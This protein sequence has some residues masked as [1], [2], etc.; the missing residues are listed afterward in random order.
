MVN[1]TSQ[2]QIYMTLTTLRQFSVIACQ[3]VRQCDDVFTTLLSKAVA[4]LC[5]NFFKRLVNRNFVVFGTFVQ[6]QPSF[7][8]KTN[9]ANESFFVFDFM[10]SRQICNWSADSLAPLFFLDFEVSHKPRVTL[11][12]LS[13][14][15]WM[16]SFDEVEK[17]PGPEIENVVITNA[18]YS[19]I[20]RIK[21][22]DK[23]MPFSKLA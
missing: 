20:E 21:N 7:I 13:F 18:G 19:H 1:M 11:F 22:F 4:K 23:M 12:L 17:I 16:W 5:D 8:T 3:H 15:F 2:N 10:S 6:F 14:T 9:E